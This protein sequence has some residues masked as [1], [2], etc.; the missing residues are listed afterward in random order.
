MLYIGP[1]KCSL[2]NISLQIR[3]RYQF[4]CHQIDLGSSLEGTPGR[5][6]SLLIFEGQENKLSALMAG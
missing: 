4:S 2:S 1:I 6:S 5:T 3:S